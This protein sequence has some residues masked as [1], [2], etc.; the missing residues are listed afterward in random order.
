M[1]KAN[2][3]KLE[4]QTRNKDAKRFYALGQQLISVL[5]MFGFLILDAI[6]SNDFYRYA[7][8]AAGLILFFSVRKNRIKRW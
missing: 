4:I 1:D 5:M 2:T 8:I 3:G 6:R 7:A